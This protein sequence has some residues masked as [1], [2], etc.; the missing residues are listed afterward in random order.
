MI[1]RYR[2]TQE[3]SSCESGDCLVIILGHLE[4]VRSG[5]GILGLV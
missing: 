4:N 3:R 5:P 2:L 1:P